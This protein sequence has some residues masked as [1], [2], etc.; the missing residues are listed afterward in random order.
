M[1]LS[2]VCWTVIMNLWWI[3]IIAREARI[4]VWF[5]RQQS[6]LITASCCLHPNCHCFAWQF[7]LI[8]QFRRLCPAF[9]WLWHYY[10]PHV[11]V[12]VQ[13]TRYL[14]ALWRITT[15]CEKKKNTRHIK[16]KEN[17]K[18]NSPLP[19][20]C[21]GQYPPAFCSAAST[22]ALKPSTKTSCV[23]RALFPVGPARLRNMKRGA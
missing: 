6:G 9:C 20:T 15:R 8:L 18:N 22:A 16:N 10:C 5:Q 3:F 1:S 23:S 13:P 19:L 12:V 11:V 2:V 21:T 4:L 17:S 14:L 7:Q